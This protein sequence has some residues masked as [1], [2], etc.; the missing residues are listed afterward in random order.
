MSVNTLSKEQ[1]YLLVKSL[2]DQAT[3]VSAI[4]PT[5]TSSFISVAQ[6]TLAAGYEPVLNAIG[7][8]LNKSLIAVRNY[9]GTFAGLQWSTERWGGITR[10]IS[11]ADTDPESENAFLL[12]DGSSIDQYVVKKPNVLETHYVGSDVWKGKY[13]I[14]ENQLDV[15]FSSPEE[16]ARFMEGLMLHFSNE[17]KQWEESMGRGLVCN[18]I[19]SLNAMG[20]GHVI[21]LLT[22]YNSA[23]GLSLTSTTVKQPANYGPFIKWCYARIEQ[24]ARLMAERSQ[25]FQRVITGKP[26]MRHSAP[27]DQKFY[28]DADALGHI[29]AEVLSSTYNDSY[30]NL[31]ETRAINFWQDIN[32]P[33]SVQVTPVDVNS[34]GVVT[35]GS[36]QTVSNIFGLI[37][38][39]DCIGYNVKSD[40]IRYSPLNADGL[41][42]NLFRHADIQYCQDTTEKAVLL[43]L[44]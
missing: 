4:T 8:V 1:A 3:G 13:T 6:S 33:S 11:F 36:A 34:S 10:K 7:Q 38:D 31:A 41:Y 5:D 23:T 40:I 43:L 44:D 39:R 17:Y 28:V 30:L 15:A 26:I 21:H 16:L 35:V 18:L 22:E 32:S 27:R 25:L 2:H 37:F 24:I 14:F 12:V 19:G 42:R 9:D 20:T 29:K